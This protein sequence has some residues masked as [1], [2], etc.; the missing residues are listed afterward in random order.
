[1]KLSEKRI[2]HLAV[3]IADKLLETRSVEAARG[4]HDLATLAAKVLNLDQRLE[5][6]IDEEARAMLARQPSLPPPGTG[7]YEAAYEQARR[8]AAMRRGIP[9]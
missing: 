4:K 5:S 9:Y 8:R 1:M 3:Q 7:E 6:E 2:R